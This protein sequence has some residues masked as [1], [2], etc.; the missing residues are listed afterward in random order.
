[1]RGI[2]HIETAK[3]FQSLPLTH[4]AAGWGCAALPIYLVFLDNQGMVQSNL[5]LYNFL[6]ARKHN[7]H[8]R[9]SQSWA[10]E[11]KG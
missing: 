3:T 9:Q 7:M 4:E 10:K 11:K 6:R 1:M 8:H 5:F 2:H